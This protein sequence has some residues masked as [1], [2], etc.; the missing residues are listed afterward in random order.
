M[1]FHKKIIY[2]YIWLNRYISMFLVMG[3]F[4]FLIIHS[5]NVVCETL[6]NSS[7]CIQFLSGLFCFGCGC[8]FLMWYVL[9]VTESTYL[10]VQ[11]PFPKLKHQ[12]FLFFLQIYI[13]V[14][15]GKYLVT[16]NLIGRYL[17]KPVP[18]WSCYENFLFVFTQRIGWLKFNT[19]PPRRP[20]YV[21]REKQNV[22]ST[23]WWLPEFFLRSVVFYKI[24]EL[25]FNVERGF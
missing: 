17:Y 14:E 15:L 3:Y 10:I 2:I 18:I 13:F 20:V 4:S 25:K 21:Y 23:Y 22:Y 1:I 11:S 7:L 12:F 9:C 5:V 19:F 8:L 24:F 6:K 16:A